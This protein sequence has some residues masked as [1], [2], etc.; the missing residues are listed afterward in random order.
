MISFAD[1]TIRNI[2]VHHVGNPVNDEPL[3]CSK[4][5]FHLDDPDLESILRSF[6]L[7]PFQKNDPGF[8]QFRHDSDIN[9]NELYHYSGKIFNPDENFVLQSVNIAHHL[10]QKSDHPRVKSGELYILYLENCLIDDELTDAVGLFKSEN[11]DVFLK[12]Y[13][14]NEQCNIEYQDGINIHKLDKGCLVFNTE[15]DLGYKVCVIDKTNSTETRF[16]TEEFLNIE[17]RND[18]FYKTRMVLNMARDFCN[19]VLPE[20][21]DMPKNKQL[22]L[23]ENVLKYFSE[24]DS[25]EA[26]TFE[27]EVFQYPQVVESFKDYKEQNRPADQQT[28]EE[29]FNIA[30]NAVKKQKKFFKSVIKLDKNFH[31]YV[32][33]NPQMLEKG[34]D[35]GKGKYFYKLYFD[36]ERD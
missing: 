2:I 34:F 30:T 25:Y 6:F 24:N 10:Y 21:E 19:T 33:G 4:A 1:T 23:K 31:I 13:T 14:E 36:Q 28:E 5:E 32:H 17:P 8:H 20:Q 26:E 3:K 27:K 12:V 9:L 16:W 7:E 15:K 22:E 11:K 29:S 18:D 35:D